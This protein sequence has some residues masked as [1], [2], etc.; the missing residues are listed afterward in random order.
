MRL[1]G[2]MPEA[3]RSF[4]RAIEIHDELERERQSTA[5]IMRARARLLLNFGNVL[6]RNG[7]LDEA[8]RNFQRAI[9]ICER[10]MAVAPASP[11]DRAQLA[12]GLSDL[13]FVRFAQGET[14]E[15]ERNVRRAVD[16][17]QSLADEFP[18]IPDHRKRLES[19]LTRLAII[20]ARMGRIKETE[21]A[22]LKAIKLAEALVAEAPAVPDLQAD[23][24]RNLGN[25]GNFLQD[26]GRSL[27][28]E[29][30][31]RRAID[32]AEKLSASF[33]KID[34]YRV[35]FVALNWYNLGDLLRANHRA[36]DAETAYGQVIEIMQSVPA[37]T[38]DV[39][40]SKLIHG[41][42]LGYAGQYRLERGEFALAARL[43]ERAVDICR[44]AAKLAPGNPDPLR[45]EANFA[46][47]LARALFAAHDRAGASAAAAEAA[48]TVTDFAGVVGDLPEA[49]VEVARV[50]ARIAPATSDRAIQQDYTIRAVESLRHAMAKGFKGIGELTRDPDLNPLSRRRDVQLFLMNRMD[51]AMPV[52]PFAR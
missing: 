44:A 8:I 49:N 11:H 12:I 33:P 30:T 31:L 27:E 45:T 10:L 9:S 37:N 2:R 24:I 47:S 50:L 20:L 25:F 7:R 4:R 41:G 35:F 46:A 1:I 5:T 42:A 3:E 28:A 52:D 6:H 36:R 40:L 13:G 39:L 51:Q 32:L 17:W 34:E 14:A 16:F 48:R 23:L 29:A 15:A 21:E 43:L 26:T 38:G 22:D 18:E 19:G